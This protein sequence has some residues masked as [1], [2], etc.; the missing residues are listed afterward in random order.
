[1]PVDVVRPLRL[2]LSP[3]VAYHHSQR[4]L[5]EA[6]QHTISRG[7]PHPA[8]YYFDKAERK[9]AISRGLLAHNQF[10]IYLFNPTLV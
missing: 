5:V 9:T 10:T 1:M 7:A 2:W 8:N 3:G 4:A 6:L